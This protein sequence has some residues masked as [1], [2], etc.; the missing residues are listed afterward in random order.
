MKQYEAM[1][2]FNSTFASDYANVESELARLMERA[3][4]EII[5]ASKW[6][7]RKLAYEINKQK[8][9]LYVL[10]FFRSPV[11]G[12]KKLEA[13]C[14]LSE[15]VLRVLILD[16][17]ELS[18]KKMDEMIA[19]QPAPVSSGGWERPGRSSGR[20]RSSGPGPRTPS[21]TIPPAEKPKSE[22][23]AKTIAVATL[24]EAEAEPKTP[25]AGEDD[26]AAT[27]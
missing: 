25:P 4:A 12:I 18:R 3:G 23:A 22:D 5:V 11:D 26:P 1:F 8:R 27:A 9:G 16:A 13:D 6:E 17:E 24:P 21:P 7:E 19:H 10:V 14:R 2:L 15:H 20:P